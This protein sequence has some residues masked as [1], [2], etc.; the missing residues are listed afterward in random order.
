MTAAELTGADP[1]YWLCEFCGADQGEPCES[2]LGRLVMV[3]ATRRTAVELWKRY[4]IG[5]RRVVRPGRV[6]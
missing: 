4:S 1:V 3:H 2:R 6:T 5:G